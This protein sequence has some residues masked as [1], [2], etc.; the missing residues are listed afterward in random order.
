M[1]PEEWGKDQTKPLSM[2]EIAKWWADGLKVCGAGNGAGLLTAGAALTPFY[3][4]HAALLLVKISGSIFLVGVIAFAL[5]FLMIYQA[6]HAQDEV[7]QGT[8]HKD[9]KRIRENSAI[10]GSSMLL[11]NKCAIVSTITFFLG[12]IVGLAAFWSF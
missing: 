7:A 5:G 1:T 10:S 8:M 11:A 3:T 12:C 2:F 6:M 9:V 4:H